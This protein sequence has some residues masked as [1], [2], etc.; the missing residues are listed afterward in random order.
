MAHGG[1]PPGSG[2]GM[3]ALGSPPSPSLARCPWERLARTGRCHQI[4]RCREASG[5]LQ[6]IVLVH[7]SVHLW[8]CPG[9][10]RGN[11]LHD[12][13][14]CL[15]LQPPA[16]QRSP[17]PLCGSCPAAGGSALQRE[18]C[19]SITTFLQIS[20]KRSI[21]RRPS[22]APGISQHEIGLDI[23]G[24]TARW[25]LSPMG[26]GSTDRQ[27]STAPGGR[28]LFGLVHPG[29]RAEGRTENNMGWKA[30]RLR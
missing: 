26:R 27:P 3:M 16:R 21:L 22:P 17:P 29:L 20:L 19:I 9:P 7:P 10:A 25:N 15:C 13:L 11:I 14:L 1:R 18:G 12:G 30:S 24:Q 28:C 2:G 8:T 4:S 6:K 5:V 23:Q